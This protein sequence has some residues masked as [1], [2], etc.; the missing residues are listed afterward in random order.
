M[1]FDKSKNE[2]NS[3]LSC[4]PWKQTQDTCALYVSMPR[5][6]LSKLLKALHKQ[7]PNAYQQC[8]DVLIKLDKRGAHDNDAIR[9]VQYHRRRGEKL[10]LEI[11]YGISDR[12][13]TVRIP[14]KPLQTTSVDNHRLLQ[15]QDTMG[16]A[17]SWMVLWYIVF[18]LRQWFR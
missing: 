4:Q 6:N 9:I 14:P 17:F 16:I 15:V 8:K 11:T 18:G 2:E 12:V 10:V 3:G 13:V 7:H 1:L 5:W